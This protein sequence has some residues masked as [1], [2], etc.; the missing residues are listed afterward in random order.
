[1]DENQDGTQPTEGSDVAGDPSPA[2]ESATPEPASGPMPAPAPASTPPPLAFDSFTPESIVK[3]KPKRGRIAALGGG[4]V[5]VVG[6]VALRFILVGA[7]AV[8]WT[9]A[10]G[11]P[12][13]KL[14]ASTRDGYEQR[15]KAAMG[16][17]I[18][19]K[20]DTEI[21][22]KMDS[23]ILDGLPRLS[24][25]LLVKRMSLFSLMYGRIDVATCA[26]QARI[27]LAATGTYDMD[28]SLVN[29]LSTDEYTALIES[30]VQAIETASRGAPAQQVP[31]QTA[32]DAAYAH[33][34][35]LLGTESTTAIVDLSNGTEMS[36]EATCRATRS[37]Y[38]HLAAVTD[39]E[40]IVL[41]R[42]F[43]AP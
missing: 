26:R 43:V 9:A 20:S 36:D 24:D 34:F 4:I 11:G 37:L 38:D 21:G 13:D 27:E 22:T 8:G 3:A 19:K 2:P 23:L 32:V 7:A 6:L 17:E 1:M 15:I 25:D 33:L 16:E 42:D 28:D 10:F 41:A 31:S 29:T 5:V 40:Q 18:F 14:P 30:N 12:W 39:A 35:D